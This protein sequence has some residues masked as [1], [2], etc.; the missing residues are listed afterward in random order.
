MGQWRKGATN[1]D[2]PAINISVHCDSTLMTY[3][4]DG[5]AGSKWAVREAIKS[6]TD[7][8]SGTFNSGHSLK[9]IMNDMMVM[10]DAEGH[11]RKPVGHE[12]P[13]PEHG[14]KS[15]AYSLGRQWPDV[16]RQ[17]YALQGHQAE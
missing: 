4:A 1:V 9:D 3:N 17:G 6:M 5:K 10:N 2:Y 13:P 7:G 15:T 12:P 8:C 14:P 11:L 16:H